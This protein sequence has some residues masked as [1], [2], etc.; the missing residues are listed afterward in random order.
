MVEGLSTALI[1]EADFQAKTKAD[2]ITPTTTA[3]ARSS[4]TVT[5]VTKIITNAS[6]LGTT[7]N[8]FKE[9]QANVARTT[10]NITPT[11]AAMGINS[12]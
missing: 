9:F 10:I 5:I 2:T 7:N 3:I 12:I 6:D 11:N 1:L 8:N 4:S